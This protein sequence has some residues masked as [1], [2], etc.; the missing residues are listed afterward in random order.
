MDIQGILF[1]SGDTLVFPKSGS[2]WPGPEFESILLQHGIDAANFESE[3]M[4][5]ALDEGYTFLDANHLVANLEEE[6][7]QFR[8]YY[9]IICNKLGINEDDELIEDLMSAYVETC[10]FQL[11]PDTVPVLEKLTNNGVIMGVISDAWPS[12]HNKY[13]SLGIRHYFKSFTISAELGCC[14]PNELIYRKATDEIGIPPKNL[15]F[16]D[17]DLDNV[18]ASIRLGMNGI[19]ILRSKVASIGE[20]PYVRELAEILDIAHI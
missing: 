3:T 16:V 10:N 7:E 18:K 20:V 12:L 5:L 13:V 14:K 1:D 4:R 6:K 2:W 9:R 17:N 8:S 11:Y 15:L 19:I